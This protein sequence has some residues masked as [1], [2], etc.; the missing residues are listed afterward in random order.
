MAICTTSCKK[1][2][3][4]QPKTQMPSDVLFTTE[5]GFQDALTG[6]YIQ[7]KST[8]AYGQD[9]TFGTIERLTSSWDVTTN[10]TE[11]RLGLFNYA[12]DGVQRALAA[13]YAQEYKI[14]ASINAILAEV[15]VR[16]DVFLSAGSYEMMKGECLALRAY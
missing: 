12:D 1:W 10:T 6:V 2:L 13:I 16:K 11:Q 14:I 9:M 15:D 8:N 7:M 3:T 5:S 4:V